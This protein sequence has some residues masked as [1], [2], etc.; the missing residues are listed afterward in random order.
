MLLSG[1]T[2][3]E[4]LDLTDTVGVI[5]LC[6]LRNFRAYHVYNYKRTF[7][8]DSPVV[9]GSGRLTEKIMLLCRLQK[10]I[11]RG[12]LFLGLW[13]LSKTD[14]IWANI[15]LHVFRSWFEWTTSTQDASCLQPYRRLRAASR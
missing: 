11:L 3:A 6:L 10:L 5:N 9:C 1:C 12:G 4:W 15:L 14:S 2:H 7:I 8:I 13:K